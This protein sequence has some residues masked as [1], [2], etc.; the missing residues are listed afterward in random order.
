M[1]HDTLFPENAGNRFKH[2]DGN[3]HNLSKDNFILTDKPRRVS[4][5]VSDTRNLVFELSD[6]GLT[7]EEI[8]ERLGVCREAIRYHRKASVHYKKNKVIWK[9]KQMKRKGNSIEEI[10]VKFKMSRS[11]VNKKLKQKTK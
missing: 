1:I 6:E 4:E 5:D 2:K 3:E 8:G 11:T 9:V 10:C 7:L